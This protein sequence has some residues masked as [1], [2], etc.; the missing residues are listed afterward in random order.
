MQRRVDDFA[1]LVFLALLGVIAHIPI[2]ALFY[3]LRGRQRLLLKHRIQL[4]IQLHRRSQLQQAVFIDPDNSIFQ[5]PVQAAE[6][7][8]M[9][10]TKYPHGKRRV[11][12]G[13]LI[14][15]PDHIFIRLTVKNSQ[16]FLGC[17]F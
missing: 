3:I 7:P 17:C 2:N 11:S 6:A 14:P 9:R 13:G 1:H 4:E 10:F 15:L 8:S 16:L 12:V 5:L